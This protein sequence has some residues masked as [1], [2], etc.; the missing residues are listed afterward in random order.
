MWGIGVGYDSVVRETDAPC[1][2]LIAAEKTYH[3]VED[4]REGYLLGVLLESFFF[5]NRPARPDYSLLRL[6]GYLEERFG[7]RLRALSRLSNSPKD[8]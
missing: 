6:P 8:C 2:H 1:S 3:T 5:E 4:T 7:G